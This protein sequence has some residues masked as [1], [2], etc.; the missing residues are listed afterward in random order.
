MKNIIFVLWI[1]FGLFAN[2]F[3]ADVQRIEEKR[4]TVRP[5]G[6]VAVIG[7]DG[8]IIIKTWDNDQVLIKTKITVYDKS[9]KRAAKRLENVEIDYNHRGNRLT[10]REYQDD[11]NKNFDFFDLF[12]PDK[13]QQ[14]RYD[15]IVDYDLKVPREVD[16]R[17]ETDEG[18]VFV[19]GVDGDLFVSTD[20]G[21]VNLE[22]IASR[23]L[24]IETDEG[25]IKIEHAKCAD[26]Q[27]TI[28]T[29]EGS[30]RL[31]DCKTAD[32]KIDTD[33]GEVV[34][35][36]NLSEKTRISTDE[37][38]VDVDMEIEPHGSYR[39][40]CDEGDVFVT[41]PGNPD[42]YLDLKSEDGNIHGD[43][44]VDS[45]GDDGER[46]RVK[47]GHGNAKLKI[48]TDEGDITVEER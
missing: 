31:L 4:F 13:W 29:D 12:D 33:E 34:L 28:D 45:D 47:L 48:F 20:E 18:N 37:G 41:L 43:F 44:A 15:I 14:A 1:T 22:N 32:L 19:T 2:L 24:N 8:D 6:H 26:G 40:T 39:F 21:T 42:V 35:Q 5:G 36:N 38:D 9:R 11:R 10:V 17:L 23:D 27:V 3:S 16:L 30:V 7:D 46:L 25:R